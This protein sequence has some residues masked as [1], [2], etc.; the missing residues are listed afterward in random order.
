MTAGGLPATCSYVVE[1][2][3]NLH[4]CLTLL[5][6]EIHQADAIVIGMPMYILF[7]VR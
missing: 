4:L 5:I 2:G 3:Y 7:G 1:A 6:K